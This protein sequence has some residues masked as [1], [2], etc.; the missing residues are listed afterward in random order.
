MSRKK[1]YEDYD[2]EFENDED[3][4]DLA[5]LIFTLI[6]RWKL[7]VLTAIPVVILGVIFAITRPTVYQAETTLIVSNNMSSVS[8]DSSDIS[9]SQRLVITY[10]EIAKNKSILNKVINKY[11]LKETTEQLAKLVTITPVDS[12]ELISLTYK[13]SDPQLAAMVTNEIANE[14]MDKV[15]Q[16]MRVRNVNIVEKAQVSV[17]P[18]PKKRALILLASVVLGLAAGTGMAFI[19]EF[20]HKKLRK[21]SE[22]Q[23]ILGVSMIG[24]IPDLENVIA[25][26]DEDSNE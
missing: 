1:K 26:K 12:T 2:E 9:L 18:L 14:F 23:A 17:Q 15:V 21:P 5:D 11:D 4:I 22:I 24:M 19:M 20:L 6:R 7:I 16:V 8:L 3:E 13:N 25:E 10:S